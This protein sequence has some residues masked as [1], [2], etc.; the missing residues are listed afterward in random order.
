[1]TEPLREQALQQLQKKRGFHTH[2]AVYLLVNTVLW[3]IWAVL[4]A[5]VGGLWLPWPLLPTLGWGIGIFFHAWDTYG[6]KPFTE[7]EIQRELARLRPTVP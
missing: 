5:T 1:M 3:V 6:R 4:L 7:A 2:L